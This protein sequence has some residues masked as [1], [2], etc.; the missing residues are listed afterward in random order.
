MFTQHLLLCLPPAPPPERPQKESSP[1]GGDA[2]ALD[3][4]GGRR[5]RAESTSPRAEGERRGGE[6]WHWDR[7]GRE[8]V[9]RERLL[10]TYHRHRKPGISG[11]SL[12]PAQASQ[13]KTNS[14]DS[15]TR[16][17]QKWTG[18]VLTRVARKRGRESEERARE[19]GTL[20]LKLREGTQVICK[21]ISH[22]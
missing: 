3:K 11:A 4:G 19:A 22:W 16:D 14:Q 21:K 18:I 7:R 1:A 15:K 9:M 20:V 5:N 8:E 13:I 2:A 12:K 17:L 6:I 10:A